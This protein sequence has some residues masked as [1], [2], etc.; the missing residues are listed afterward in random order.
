VVGNCNNSPS[1]L[2]GKR[3]GKLTV[4]NYAESRAQPSGKIRH[5]WVCLCDCGNI[6]P[7]VSS[8]NL[9][10]KN[11]T[12]SCGC[13]RNANAIAAVVKHGMYRTPEYGA[14]CNL[15][16]RCYRKSHKSYPNYGGRGITVCERWRKSFIN[17]IE[18]MGVRPSDNLSIDR[19]D[20]E[21]GYFPGNCKWRTS[22]EQTSNRR[23]NVNLTFNGMTK[24]L[25]Q[26]AECT[27]ISRS[28]LDK[29]IKNGWS[30]KDTLSAPVRR[31]NKSESAP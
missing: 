14:W 11:G 12:K 13:V 25:A 9:L 8:S 20:N 23:C 21:K 7:S 6:S 19:I 31:V 29:R 16:A 10:K 27:G 5:R 17:F 28:S 22:K 30:T 18:D 24:T 3:F 1:H 15:I 4:I 26:W 2:I